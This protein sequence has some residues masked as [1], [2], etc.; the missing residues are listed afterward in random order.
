MKQILLTVLFYAS[1]F[2]VAQSLNTE[3]MFDGEFKVAIQEGQTFNIVVS[4]ETEVYGHYLEGY[5]LVN[6][7]D[8]ISVDT[9]VLY[10]GFLR[11][12]G[13]GTIGH[14]KYKISVNG[15]QIFVDFR[16]CDYHPQINGYT[17]ADV[18][19]KYHPSQHIFQ[20][21]NVETK[22]Y[23]TVQL[24]STIY[25]WGDGRKGMEGPPPVTD[26]FESPPNT[27]TTPPQEP[28]NLVIANST[29][30]GSFVNLTWNA[31][32]ESDLNHYNVWRKCIYWVYPIDCDLHVIGSTST[33]NFTDD[34]IRIS[35]NDGTT[36]NFVYYVSAV[37][38]SGNESNLSGSVSTWGE[39][40]FKMQDETGDVYNSV[41]GDF[42]LESN[43]P[44]P[45]NPSTMIRYSLP[46]ASAV[47]LVVYD[48]KG[49]EITKWTQNN[50]LAGYKQISW[51]GKDA[52]GNRVSA[53]VYI[54][55]LTAQSSESNQIFT[56]SRKMVF[57]K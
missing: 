41:P 57:M 12:A 6:D 47:S 7:Y 3:A 49:N 35:V 50:A 31:N 14:A 17:T 37:D 46:E 40:F 25:V 39:S 1:S 30:I 42:A 28:T 51:N 44:N 11:N 48:L 53:G 34:E 24:N 36:D 55:K 21:K 9:T 45:F 33:N 16:D 26:C 20:V 23:R 4:A 38:N 5:P 54:Y 27:D 32:S 52:N 2:I 56:Q 22:I 43:Y 18:E 19:I 8:Y 10:A 29:E 13:V 15:D